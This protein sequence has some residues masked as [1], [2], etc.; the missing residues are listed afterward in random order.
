MRIRNIELKV[1]DRK[2]GDNLSF[3]K[4]YIQTDGGSN[5]EFKWSRN[6]VYLSPKN[7]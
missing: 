5:G 2:K 7:E 1:H 4:R 3:A 6:S